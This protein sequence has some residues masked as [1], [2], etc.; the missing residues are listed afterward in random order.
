MKCNAKLRPNYFSVNVPILTIISRRQIS[1][2]QQF[3]LKCSQ[4]KQLGCNFPLCCTS[5]LS[6]A[7]SKIVPHS[8][9][10]K[11]AKKMSVFGKN[12]S[13]RLSNSLQTY[14]FWKFHHISRTDNQ[15]SYNNI[16]F[17]KVAIIDDTSAFLNFFFFQ[18]MPA[19]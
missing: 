3:C 10:R 18:K 7:L 9:T 17:A 4:K 12:G 11:N 8:K 13:R 6:I 2:S 1:K 15:I 16:W 5:Y 19:L 14:I